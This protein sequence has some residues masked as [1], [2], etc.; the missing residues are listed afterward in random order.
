MRL[1][2]HYCTPG[3]SNSY[4]LGTEYNPDVPSAEK[5]EA[6]IID[7]GVMD[8]ATL[9]RIE[10]NCYS[11]EGVLLT[12]DHATHISGLRSLRRIYDVAIYA[13]STQVMDYKTNIVH[14][15][16]VLRIGSAF[17]VEVIFVPGHSPDSVAYKIGNLLFTGDTLSAGLLGN[18]TSSFG[19]MRQISTIQN[20]LFALAGDM[21][22]MPGHG[23]PSTLNVEREFNSGIGLFHEK[24]RTSE[25]P[26]YNLDFLE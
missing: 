23:P 25:L 16:D 9:E 1:Y 21:L 11:L 13:A 4:V 6:I 3:F 19:A 17:E 12:H 10:N 18:T 5:R 8:K 2:N 22:V 26:E 20:K 24:M 14:D 15:G 7:P